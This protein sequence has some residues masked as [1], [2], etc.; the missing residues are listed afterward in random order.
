MEV[1]SIGVIILTAF[2]LLELGAMVA[3]GYW[4]YHIKAG[5]AVKIM[6]VIASPLVVAILWGVFLSPKASLSIFSFPFRTALKL[7]VFVVASAAL[8]AAGRSVLGLAF[9]MLS[10]FIVAAVFI[11]RLHKV[12]I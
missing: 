9:L 4:G 6:L 5:S 12:K 2:F 11:L 3:F 7:V 10:L 8:Y 1:K